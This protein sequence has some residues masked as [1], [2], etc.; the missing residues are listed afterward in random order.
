MTIT[1]KITNKSDVTD[2]I[3]NAITFINNRSGGVLNVP[4][5]TTGYIIIAGEI[6]LCNNLTINFNNNYIY[7]QS[8]DI[9]KNLFIGANLKNV[10]F[11]D[12]NIIS[13]NDKT[14]GNNRSGLGSN[15]YG[16]SLHGENI[17]LKNVYSECLEKTVQIKNIRGAIGKSQKVKIENFRSYKT[18]N[19][20]YMSD[21]NDSF[22][23]QMNLDCLES[24][25]TFDH[26]IYVNGNCNNLFFQDLIF[27]NGNG[28]SLAIKSD[29][30]LTPNQGIYVNNISLKETTGVYFTDT[31]K[32]FLNR[33]EIKTTK[34]NGSAFSINGNT[35]EIFI[36]GFSVDGTANFFSTNT[37]PSRNAKNIFFSNGV[38]TNCNGNFV[39]TV[40]V[41]NALYDNMIFKG[42]PV[43]VGG[44]IFST[45]G[46]T[47]TK[48]T[49]TNC[50]FIT[51][52]AP[53][54]QLIQFKDNAL[55][56]IE[57][58]QFH[59]NS[60]TY[61]HIMVNTTPAKVIAKN[62]YFKG[63]TNFKHTTSD[64]ATTEYNN[65]NLST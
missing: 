2:D 56:V 52:V 35:S 25:D 4:F 40:E 21:V 62:N 33:F 26:Q 39:S 31:S 47:K 11:Q 29:N 6:T 63:Y 32:V 16:F 34:T 36:N 38:V 50:Q 7:V 18:K 1:L 57:N 23:S 22:F 54:T 15:V 45:S 30:P 37:T 17:T 59:N 41:D 51:D 3:Q 49:L 44:K 61:D 20:L 14:R 46:T 8:S 27:K 19:P 43:V 5:C 64:T 24:I 42:L 58:C 28:Y 10:L 12:V 9:A 55:V 13:T 65:I 48:C 53:T 60:T